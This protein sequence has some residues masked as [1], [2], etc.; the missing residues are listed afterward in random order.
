M[1]DFPILRLDKLKD[2]TIGIYQMG[3]AP[4]YIQDKLQRDGDNDEE[5]QLNMLRDAYQLPI[6]GLMRVR[7]YSRYQNAVKYQ[8]LISYKPVIE[9]NEDLPDEENVLINGYYCL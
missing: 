5:F 2:I 1:N 9:S 3:L 8:L 4:S 6:P 7:V